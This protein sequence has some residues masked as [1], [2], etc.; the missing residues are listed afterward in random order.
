VTVDV[1]LE[2]GRRDATIAEAF[3]N[4]AL[5]V[6]VVLTCNTS[7]ET[8]VDSTVDLSGDVRETIDATQLPA[9]VTD[10]ALCTLAGANYDNLTRGTYARAWSCPTRHRRSP[11]HHRPPVSN[12]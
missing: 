6:L 3:V 11:D 2:P 10:E 1:T 7:T 5:F 9:G 4:S 8:L 12:S